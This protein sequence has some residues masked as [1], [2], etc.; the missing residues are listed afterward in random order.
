[1]YINLSSH[2]QTKVCEWSELEAGIKT[3]C[4]SINSDGVCQPW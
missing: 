3:S 2:H 4:E 1:M